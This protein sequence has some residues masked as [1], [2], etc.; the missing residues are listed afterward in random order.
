MDETDLEV[1]PRI[2]VLGDS[3]VSDW[4]NPLATTARAV[5]RALGDLGY[6]AT[7]LEPRRNSPTVGLLS[8]RGAGPVLGFNALR[9]DLQYRTVDLPARHEVSVWIGQFAAT[10]GIIIALEGTSEM[11]ERGLAEFEPEGIEIFVERPE[12]E[13]NWGRTR[14]Q[15]LDRPEESVGF[16]PAV[17]PETWERPRAGTLLVAYDDPEL[18]RAVADRVP[19][20]R[21]I[22]SGSADL[23]DWE[24]I[25]EIELPPLYGVAE[26]VLI[27]DN[28]DR[29]IAPVRVWL[30]RA[31]GAPA[32]GIVHDQDIDA[33]VAIPLSDVDD[34]LTRDNPPLPQRLDA[35]WVAS[36]LID[37]YHHRST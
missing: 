22:V 32:W 25:P 3:I 6:E 4:R 35:R 20:A 24:F 17:L 11:I 18:A 27:V 10:T 14:L 5:L 36:S 37:L 13:G 8:Q 23:P 28:A 33:S 30:P 19:D 26:R 2:V 16:R 15:R 21:R 1:A 29:P 9:S 7:Y 34:A 31:N 12:F